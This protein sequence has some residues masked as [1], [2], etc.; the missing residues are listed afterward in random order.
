MKLDTERVIHDDEREELKKFGKG[1]EW[2]RILLFSVSG[3]A[4]SLLHY[5]M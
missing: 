2:D 5:K 1:Q 4:V 3:G